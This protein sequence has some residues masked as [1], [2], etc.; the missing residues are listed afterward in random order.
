MDYLHNFAIPS[1]ETRFAFEGPAFG[2]SR[3]QQFAKNRC[4]ALLDRTGE[5]ARPY[6]S[7]AWARIH[8]S[9]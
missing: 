7:I 5:G 4:R 1:D 6:V 8:N 3:K 9:L 2:E